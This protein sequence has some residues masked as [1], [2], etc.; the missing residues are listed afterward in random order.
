MLGL[1]FGGVAVAHSASRQDGAVAASLD[2]SGSTSA[3]TP[4]AAPVAP[5]DA[6]GISAGPDPAPTRDYN[7]PVPSCYAPTSRATTGACS[8]GPRTAAHRVAIVGDSHT[9]AW[10]PA[11]ARAANAAGTRVDMYIKSG[12]GAVVT[13]RIFAFPDGAR[14]YTECETWQQRTFRAI[15][16]SSPD[17]VLLASASNVWI[18]TSDSDRTD[19]ATGPAR[20]QRWAAGMRAAIDRYD[21]A[22]PVVAWLGDPTVST[23]AAMSCDAADPSCGT[24]AE[25]GVAVGHATEVAVATAEGIPLFDPTPL[26]CRDGW[27][28]AW[29]D[30]Y[31]VHRNGGHLSYQWAGHSQQVAD[32][33][34][35]ALHDVT[36]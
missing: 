1:T 36:S 22:T 34:A 6:A 31:R 12:C 20:S 29:Q 3:S 26:L 35:A 4:A 11:V 27:C 10:W 2:D 25:V 14:R 5:V 19:L 30:G 28:P 21:A 7:G 9:W 24:T 18:P 8:Y 16:A 33:F 17:A 13:T 15:E 32:F 23:A